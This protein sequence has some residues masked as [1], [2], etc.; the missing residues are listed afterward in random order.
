MPGLDGLELLRVVRARK[1]VTELPVIMVTGRDSGA[2]VAE[3]LRGGAND[4]LTKPV[5]FEVALARLSTH[6]RWRRAQ[7]GLAEKVEEVLKLADEL[8]LRNE[9]IKQVFGRYVSDA[10]VQSVLGSPQG[11]ELGGQRRSVSVLMGDLRG[12]TRL[13]E[14]L[15]PEQVVELLNTYLGAMA[16]VIV[17]Y[18][19]VVDEFIGDA[20]LAIFGAPVPRADHAE[21]AVACALAMQSAMERVNR[22][23][24]RMHLGSL[25][26]GIGVNTGEVVVGNIGSDKRAKYGVVGAQVNLA[27]R[28]QAVT[29]GGEVLVSDATASAVGSNLKVDGTFSIQSKGLG[30]PVKLHCVTG[31]RGRDHLDLPGLEMMT[32][33]P[34]KTFSVKIHRFTDAKTP[35]SDAADGE[36]AVT[37]HRYGILRTAEQLHARCEL[38]LVRTG[39]AAQE[40]HC[41]VMKDHPSSQGWLIRFTSTPVGWM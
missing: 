6:L 40:L 10:V 4:Y 2:D 35:T 22:R 26:M 30:A 27:G 13:A 41:K 25:E 3:A 5:D 23:L 11:L 38:K 21:L 36:L 14:Q 33:K 28:I 16:D 19:G 34:E 15:A 20:V 12:F 39:G 32:A 17:Q 18:H 7:T 8:Q 37:S 9:F 24:S 29:V 31:L 1:S